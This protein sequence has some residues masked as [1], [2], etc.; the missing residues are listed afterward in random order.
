MR[1]E[2]TQLSLNPSE[3]ARVLGAVA[4]LLVLGSI[5]GQL[6]KFLLGHN[7]VKG[8]IPLF[9]LNGEQNI[10]TFFSVLL[11]ICIALLLA[12]IAVLKRKQKTHDAS[13]LAILSFLFLYMAYDE[14]FQV[15]EMLIA[16][17][18]ELLGNGNL[19]ILY[20]AWVIPGLA[21]VLV[22]ALFFA[23]FVLC[24][25]TATRRA[26]LMAAALYV[27]GS[28]GFELIGGAYDELHGWNNLKYNMISTAEESLEIAG[29][30]VF[31]WALLKYCKHS[32][33]E[34]RFRFGA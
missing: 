9:D 28:I 17:V 12:V 14:G 27:G 2:T 5:G 25:P 11:M 10:P 7:N 29:L 6:S 18:R 34:V 16:P 8:L 20:Y 24:L 22:V 23:R 13:K 19:G 32:F 21:L 26:F 4:F 15:H 3:V 30:I 1:I 31:L 33:K